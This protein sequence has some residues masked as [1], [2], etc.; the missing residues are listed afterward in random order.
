MSCSK[1]KKCKAVKRKGGQS[2]WCEYC[3][4]KYL[5]S[6][7]SR[8]DKALKFLKK[9]YF[10]VCSSLRENHRARHSIDEP[11]KKLITNHNKGLE[12]L[13]HD[14]LKLAV[15]IDGESLSISLKCDGAFRYKSSK[16]NNKFIFYELKGYGKDTNSVFSAILASQLVQEFFPHNNN[17][18]YFYLGL[19][20]GGGI[21]RD[22]LTKGRGT[23]LTPAVKWAESKGFIKFYGICDVSDMLQEITDFC[24]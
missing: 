5:D 3:G 13:S 23:V 2:V 1:V 15:V 17:Y 24:K 16:G 4:Y 7:D 6:V 10:D 20:G 11:F 12:E 21:S 18:K 9:E 8:N 19:S 22:D 14:E